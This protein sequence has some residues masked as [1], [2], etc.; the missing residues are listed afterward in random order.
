VFQ[1]I[2]DTIVA[3]SSPP[4]A[5]VRGV[6]RLSGPRAIQI[7][8]ESLD[9]ADRRLLP[10]TAGQRRLHVRIQVARSSLPAELYVFRSPASYTRQDLV[11]SHIVG[12]PPLLAILMDR[13]VA[14]GAR[15]AEPGEFTARAFFAGALDLT[16][17]EGVAAAISARTDAQL[18]ASQ[19]LLHGELGRRT[20]RFREELADLLALIEAEIDFVDESI[21]F[22]SPAAAGAK[23]EEIRGEIDHLLAQ[24]DSCERLE[25]L[26]EIVFLGP[27]NAGKSTLFNRLTGT[28]RAIQS[29]V[30]GTTR[31]VLK[32]PVALAGGDAL[33]CD[34]AGVQGAFEPDTPLD[35]GLDAMASD[36][37][38]RAAQTADHVL[39][40]LD[41]TR[42]SDAIRDQLL[43]AFSPG[44]CT[45]VLNKA[46]ML[47]PAHRE[48]IHRAAPESL[49]VSGLDGEG[50]D[51]LVKALNCRLF[52]ESIARAGDIL[53]LT[54]RQTE[55]LREARVALLSVSELMSGT[56]HLSACAELIAMEFREAVSALSLLTG[57]VTTEDLL[58]RIFSRFCI[59]K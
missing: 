33:L 55:A 45:V 14:G 3:I 52:S 11:E 56:T 1:Q 19:H 8:G 58:G 38:W 4:G 42:D 46:D 23:V 43:S 7:V 17:V 31:D 44:R 54:A 32:V 40:V 37:A 36:T 50:V 12:S 53:T 57:E 27:P 15:I 10:D 25:W 51:A 59:G 18:R 35:C 29:A 26:P 34:S 24:S 6:L 48:I 49:L 39:L 9:P 16:R 41:V 5:A 20:S 22:V 28:D 13:M 47:T 21:S 2:D 30:A